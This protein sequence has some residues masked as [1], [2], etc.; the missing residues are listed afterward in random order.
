MQLSMDGPSLNCK[1]LSDMRK[2]REEA[3]LNHLVNIGSC[4]LHVVHGALQSATE[5]KMWN[6][7]ATMK[8]LFEIFKDSP[9]LR[10]DF[11]SITAS[12]IFPLQFF[13]TR[14]DFF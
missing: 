14:F 6:L 2:E 12:T 7:K 1:V 4:N 13:P 11:I 10:E 3:G 9:A 5:T 8:G